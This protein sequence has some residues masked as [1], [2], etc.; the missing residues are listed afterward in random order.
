VST[1]NLTDTSY[2]V[3]GL[4]DELGPSTPYQLK[5][6][7]S[8]SVFHFWTI[9]HTQIYTECRK[10]AQAGLVDEQR[11]ETGRRRRTYR[12]T[13]KGRKALS[14]W[15]DDPNTDFYELKDPGLLKLFAGGDPAALAETQLEA[16]ERRL[17]SYEALRDSMRDMPEGMRLALDAGIG[18][19]REY[20]RFWSRLRE[21]RPKR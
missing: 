7:A 19:A 2:A 9:P 4:I 18:H 6:V 17:H 12:L 16:H 8:I 5:S 21:Q 20:V 10:L 11:E 1:L 13:A 3:L 15:R 14:E